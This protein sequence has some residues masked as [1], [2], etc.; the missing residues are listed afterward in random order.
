L[1]LNI[2]NGIIM[3]YW[4]IAKKYKFILIYTIGKEFYDGY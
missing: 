3:V 1:T 4:F 2:K